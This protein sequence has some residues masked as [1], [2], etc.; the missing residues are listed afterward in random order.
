MTTS[1]NASVT[2]K[3]TY[4][5]TNLNKTGTTNRTLALT[6]THGTDSTTRNHL[7]KP[8]K[9]SISTTNQ[10]EHPYRKQPP[11]T[12]NK[13]CNPSINTVK[14]ATKRANRKINKRTKKLHC[15]LILISNHQTTQAIK[16]TKNNDSTRPDNV[17]I[18]HLKHP[19]TL[20]INYLTE[21]FNLSLNPSIISQIW[22]LAKIIPI[23]KS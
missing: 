16:D 11:S 23:P 5:K 8:T 4:G 6:G 13:H 3:R 7:N 19:G 12:N 9:T 21:I 2:T 10:P 20:A 15:K 1:Q 17:N 22:K 14:H 18:R